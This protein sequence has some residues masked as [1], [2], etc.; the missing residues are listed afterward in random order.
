VRPPC[1]QG[2]YS[3]AW[4][5]RDLIPALRTPGRLEGHQLELSYGLA[6]VLYVAL[7]AVLTVVL[8]RLVVQGWMEGANCAAQSNRAHALRERRQ[9]TN[10]T[11]RVPL[12]AAKI[13]KLIGGCFV[14]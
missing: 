4:L 5:G 9:R 1:A 6:S 13:L 12:S 14:L 11:R 8:Y 2:H 3:T 10:S 7:M